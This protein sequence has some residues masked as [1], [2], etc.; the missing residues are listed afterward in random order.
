MKWETKVTLIVTAAACILLTCAGVL[1]VPLARARQPSVV[2]NVQLTNDT[3]HSVTLMVLRTDRDQIITRTA[4]PSTPNTAATTTVQLFAG[5]SSSEF[6]D[7][8]FLFVYWSPSGRGHSALL[9]GNQLDASPQP[10]KLS[11]FSTG[12]SPN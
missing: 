12:G 11:S 1:Y 6:H 10:I 4:L 9:T 3:D 2:R 5:H 8:Q 7:A